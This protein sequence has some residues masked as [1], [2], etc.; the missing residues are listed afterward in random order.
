MAYL[1]TFH[2]STCNLPSGCKTTGSTRV[3]V[4]PARSEA[5]LTCKS[6][7]FTILLLASSGQD[8]CIPD[9]RIRQTL[10]ICQVPWSMQGASSPY[11]LTT[12]RDGMM[13]GLVYLISAWR[14]YANM[15]RKRSSP[16]SHPMP[17]IVHICRMG[18]HQGSCRNL[19]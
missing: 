18:G 15:P 4:I 16:S 13:P 2:D 14:L 7:N 3:I 17:P 11:V 12:C 9:L 1:P 5:Q 19:P 8:V 6:S 10:Y